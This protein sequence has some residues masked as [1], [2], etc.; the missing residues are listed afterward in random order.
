MG[1]H[2]KNFYFMIQ[3]HRLWDFPY[4]SLNSISPTHFPHVITVAWFFISNH[5]SII[6]LF[7]CVL[8]LWYRQWQRGQHP[9][10]KIYQTDLQFG[11]RDV[12]YTT[13]SQLDMQVSIILF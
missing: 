2:L 9:V 11:S 1:S 6:L 5:K 7:K 12:H 13:S 8:T 3:F 10:V 4:P